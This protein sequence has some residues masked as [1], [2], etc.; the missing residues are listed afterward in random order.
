MMDDE[1]NR[2][3]AEERARKLAEEQQSALASQ[4][5]AVGTFSSVGIS[6]MGFGSNLQ[7]RIADAAA[8]TA[9]NTAEMVKQGKGE[10]GP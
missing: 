5:E 3:D 10:V 1:R 4:S 8:E 6:G 9:K 2:R 7:Q